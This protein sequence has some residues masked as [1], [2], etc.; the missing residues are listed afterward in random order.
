MLE[1]KKQIPLLVPDIG[2]AENIELVQ[3][4]IQEGEI[5]EEGMELCE[6]V[7]SKATFPLES[8]FNGKIIKI[9]K[10]AGSTVK[11]GEELAI[12]EIS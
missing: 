4:N 9:L 6:L 8:P 12:I 1:Q 10:P 5:V 11:I 2:D 3:W 7:T